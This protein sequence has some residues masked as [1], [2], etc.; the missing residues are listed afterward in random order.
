A[1]LVQGHRAKLVVAGLVRG[2]GRALCGDRRAL[3]DAVLPP[4]ALETHALAGA[5]DHR[6]PR[7]VERVRPRRLH[8]P[9]RRVVGADDVVAA[10]D[11]VEVV[12]LA[13]A[14][15]GRD[16]HPLAAFDHAGQVRLEFHQP[17][18]V[19]VVDGHTR[20]SSSNSTDRSCRLRSITE[21]CHGPA[22]SRA[23]NT[24]R[25]R[26]LMLAKMWKRPS[27]WRSTGA[28][29]PWP[30]MSC[31]SSSRYSGPSGNEGMA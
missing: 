29:M 6:L 24:C 15:A 25:P 12:A 21:C 19:V 17:Y 18:L 1:T 16:D 8:P 9:D 22:G 31:P 10:I 11:L 13:H 3:T 23:V 26:S 14:I 5:D 27:W 20:P 4:A 2:E 7:S 30:Y 28:Q